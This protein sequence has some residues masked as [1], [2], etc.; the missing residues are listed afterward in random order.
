MMCLEGMVK[1]G[2]AD[3]GVEGEGR[4]EIKEE[5]EMES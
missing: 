4:G 2:G 5:D 3:K 1:G